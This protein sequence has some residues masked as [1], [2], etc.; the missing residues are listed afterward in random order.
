MQKLDLEKHPIITETKG[1][2][3]K[4]VGMELFHCYEYNEDK[5]LKTEYNGRS[6]GATLLELPDG[7]L[8][9]C[10]IATK[11]SPNDEC[12]KMKREGREK[13]LERTSKWFTWLLPTHIETDMGN[14]TQLSF[15]EWLMRD[16]LEGYTPAQKL[17]A[18]KNIVSRLQDQTQ[19]EQLELNTS[20][21]RYKHNENIF[22]G[23]VLDAEDFQE[24]IEK[25]IIEF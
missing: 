6:I 17:S 23:L 5:N 13:I 20:S 15:K 1:A 8:K 11:C 16:I 10:L 4:K 19:Q 2:E 9:V 22:R 14:V 3:K 24:T 18:L 7:S 21:K 25:E 12:L